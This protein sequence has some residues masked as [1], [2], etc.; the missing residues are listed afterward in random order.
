[1]WSR[2]SASKRLH[3][4]HRHRVQVTACAE[5]DRNH[6]LLNRHR[7]VLRLLEQLDQPRT[8]LQLRFRGGVE[9]GSERGEGLQL[10][11]LRQVQ[12]Q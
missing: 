6:L 10:A 4:L 1:M 8:A 5:E 9:V 11:V 12:A 3:V 7:L 2:N